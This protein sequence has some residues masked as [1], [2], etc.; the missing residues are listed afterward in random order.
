MCVEASAALPARSRPRAEELSEAPSVGLP[1][2][3]S[4]DFREALLRLGAA[5]AAGVAIGI[6]REWRDK[7]AGIR[8]LA[9]VALGAA[10][11]CV[12]TVHLGSLQADP[13]AVSRVVQ[14]V[15]QGVMAG[16]GFLGSGAVIRRPQDGDVDGLTTAATVWVT[17]AI[18]IACGLASW[19]IA[20]AA[21]GLTLVVLVLLHPMDKFVEA[22]RRKAGKT[23]MRD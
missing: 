16:I 3:T 17:A 13:D 22:R 19:D 9:L 14:G 6:D 12:A 15:I 10:L 11:V 1:V 18:G 21:V 7:P 20:L 23:Q 8:T 2:E 4:I 5:V